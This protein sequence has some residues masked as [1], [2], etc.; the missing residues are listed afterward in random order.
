M[1]RR[2][3]PSEKC[4]VVAKYRL[5]HSCANAWIVIAIVLWDGLQKED[6][7]KAYSNLSYNL[8]SWKH[9]IIFFVG[10]IVFFIKRARL[11]FF[12]LLIC[13][14][15]ARMREGILIFVRLPALIAS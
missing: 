10:R 11:V 8:V 3:S 7:D 2:S 4:L 13:M 1:I 14:V 12:F 6:G 15:H 9:F 5:G